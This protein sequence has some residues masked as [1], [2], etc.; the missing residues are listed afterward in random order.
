[1]S[2]LTH[3]PVWGLLT[4]ASLDALL[5]LSAG[6]MPGVITVDATADHAM[7]APRVAITRLMI[8]RAQALAGLTLTATGALSRTDVRALFDAMTWPGY[9][10]AQ[11]LLMNKV[12]NE[13]DVMPV[14]AT[15]L[16]AE[17]AKLFRKRQR[18]LL[19]T[20]AGADLA[21][22][23]QASD[24]FRCLFE[25]M[26]WHVNLG[27]FDR[28]PM[29]A[30]P[31]NHIGIV[32]WYLSVMSPEWVAREHLMRSCTVWDPA[33]DHGPADYAGFAFESRV[34]RPLTWLG[35]FETR[36]VGDESAP[37]WRRERQ[38]RKAPLFDQAI[39]FR[40]ELAKPAGLSH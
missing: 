16:V 21:H 20:K 23:E 12:L 11:L 39:R 9:D 18:R 40:I 25:T 19:V 8:A 1:M 13:I 7:A 4:H 22:E 2:T 10:K 36:S 5:E 3:P 27:Y 33:L 37:F 15:R 17:T 38:Y 26:F 35:L 14:E 34:L 24:L 32:L 28:V 29:E 30:W 6:G 31:Q